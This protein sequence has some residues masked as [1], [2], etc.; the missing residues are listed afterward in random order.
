MCVLPVL[1]LRRAFSSSSVR[2]AL[3]NCEENCERSIKV[4]LRL[5]HLVFDILSVSQ[6][7]RHVINNGNCEGRLQ[8]TIATRV[9]MFR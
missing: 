8:R 1:S 7:I 4:R 6:A 5:N 9:K 2:F 3:R